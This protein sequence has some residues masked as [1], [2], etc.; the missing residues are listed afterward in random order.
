MNRFRK[1]VDMVRFCNKKACGSGPR[2][3][4][5]G[6]M[7]ALLLALL[8][9][10]LRADITATL[11]QDAIYDGD[12][13]TLIIETTDMQ[14]DGE[15]DVDVL[16]Q[17]FEIL[18]TRNSR[19][20][21]IINGQRSD[22]RQWHIELL[23]KNS[24][25]VTVPA[26]SV[27]AETTR[28][29]Q[30]SVQPPP[31]ADAADIGQPVFVKAEIEPAG[32][33]A[34][35]QQQLHYTLRLFYREGL[36]EGSFDGLEIEHA[37]IEQLG[38][39]SRYNAT[40]NGERYQVLERRYAIFPEQSGELLIPAVVFNGRLAGERLRRG[41]SSDM[42]S[43]MER[44]F[45]DSVMRAPGKRIRLRTDAITL[46]IKPRPADY[47]GEYWLPGE[48]LE[49]TDS[50]ADG[51]PEFRTGEPVTRTV[52]LE[53]KGLESSHLPD[54]SLPATDGVRMYPEPAENETRTD[55]K[56]VYGISKQTVAYVPVATGRITLPEIRID[57][58]DT[59]LLQQR[60]T[61]IPAWEINVLAGEGGAAEALPPPAEAKDPVV[62]RDV[63]DVD[64]ADVDEA[65][66]P[67]LT[68]SQLVTVLAVFLLLAL[69]TAGFAWR[70]RANRVAA[71]VT[72]AP[73]VSMKQ[74]LATSAASLEKACQKNDPQ[75]AA[76]AL[77]QWAAASWPD[78][79]PRNLG[80]LVQRLAGGKTE[81][82]E[83]ERALYAANTEAWQGDALWQAF[84]HGLE[85]IAAGKPSQQETLA[86]LYPDWNRR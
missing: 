86:P 38:D 73:V 13:V 34:Y 26:I 51:P 45:G 35:V 61:V 68:L 27:G 21:Q 74:Q 39:D 46:D 48:Q 71:E 56:W 24:G 1:I 69:I 75:A 17:D 32:G 6:L 4:Y 84:S 31:E 41:R 10:P 49:L 8:S 7:A 72:G 44:F 53:M 85:V 9:Q 58:W 23:P 40:I 3:R 36:S 12:S 52:T 25:I 59:A 79:P 78:E 81:I 82:R 11:S 66:S 28:A 5:A 29:L 43:M 14:Q 37:L 30:L 20:T 54:I 64:E 62:A 67:L 33:S 55:G 15:P 47:S 70:R 2:T 76:R 77:L 50:W 19:H 16:Q 65:G 42:G 18:G 60:S 80:A 22:K 83:L 57:W 63:A